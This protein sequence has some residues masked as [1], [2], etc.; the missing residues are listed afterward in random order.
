MPNVNLISNIGFRP[1]GTHTTVES[2]VANLPLVAMQ[3]PLKQPICFAKN[4]IYDEQT[5]K[6]Q[7]SPPRSPPLYIRAV[8]KLIRMSKR[9]C[10]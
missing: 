6:E 1:D 8:N 10:A 5:R 4:S 2:K 9:L 3:F 7:F